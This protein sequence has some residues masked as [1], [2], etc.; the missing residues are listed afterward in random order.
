MLCPR[1]VDRPHSDWI[2]PA[3]AFGVNSASAAWRALF[4][5]S[6]VPRDTVFVG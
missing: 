3:F 1:A 5:R 4:I 2:A 6:I